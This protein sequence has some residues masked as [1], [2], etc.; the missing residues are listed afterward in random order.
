M[1]EEKQYKTISD[2][3]KSIFESKERLEVLNKIKNKFGVWTIA[4]LSYDEADELIKRLEKKFVNTVEDIFM[5]K[6]EIK[7]IINSN[8]SD[9]IYKEREKFI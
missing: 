2:L 9:K 1:I 5:E 8:K 4:Q 6:K 3:L 7:K